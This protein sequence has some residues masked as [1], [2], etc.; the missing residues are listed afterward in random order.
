MFRIPDNHSYEY[1]VQQHHNHCF[2][3]HQLYYTFGDLY[4][5]FSKLLS[6]LRKSLCKKE[7]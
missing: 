2:R 6:E 7:V 3:G 4:I 1:E 5:F